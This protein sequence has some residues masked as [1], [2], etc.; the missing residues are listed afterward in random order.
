MRDETKA[1]LVIEGPYK[2]TRMARP[3]DS[4]TEVVATTMSRHRGS[5]TYYLRRHRMFGLVW[6]FK[7]NKSVAPVNNSHGDL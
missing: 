3:G 7:E 4:F 2:G 1:L 6:A 5:Y